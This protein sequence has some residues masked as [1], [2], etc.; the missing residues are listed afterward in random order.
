MDTSET[1][2]KMCDCDE[3]QIGHEREGLDFFLYYPHA[4]Y[5]NH[6]SQV[7]LPR[8]GQLQ[9]MYARYIA[10]ERELVNFGRGELMQAFIDF[11]VWL[12]VQYTKDEFVCM[13]TNT[14]DSGGQLWLAFVMKERYSK[15]W[16]TDS[17]EW[18]DG[19]SE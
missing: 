8:Q 14:F 18:I 9:E 13:P 17:Q 6:H 3:I 2:I 10:D 11:S 1:Y 15:Q 12:G 5:G 7:W 19:N 16:L 4:K